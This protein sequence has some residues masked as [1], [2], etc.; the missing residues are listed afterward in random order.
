MAGLHRDISVEVWGLLKDHIRR[1]I[2]ESCV[3]DGRVSNTSCVTLVEYLTRTIGVWTTPYAIARG[4]RPPSYKKKGLSKIATLLRDEVKR[5]NA[6]VPSHRLRGRTKD[7]L[8]GWNS[9]MS[10][11][12]NLAIK[13]GG[14][15]NYDL[16]T[17][18]DV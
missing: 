7:L 16:G 13:P 11:L 5:I 4:A 10:R 3:F 18:P 15:A 1:G 17:L 8:K 6:L 12:D 9:F 2:S 14:W